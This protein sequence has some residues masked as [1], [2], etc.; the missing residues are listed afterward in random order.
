MSSVKPTNE[1]TTAEKKISEEEKA[2]LQ[3]KCMTL[4]ESHLK[5]LYVV[6][7][8]I[9][10]LVGFDVPIKGMKLYWEMI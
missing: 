4:L 8:R 10:C 9:L 6:C 5:F 2:N 7:T 1:V 3:V